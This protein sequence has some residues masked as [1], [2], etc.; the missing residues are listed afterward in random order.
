MPPPSTRS[1]SPMPVGSRV[2]VLIS[3]SASLAPALA[4]ERAV[5]MA[6]WCRRRTPTRSSTKEF[7]APQSVQRPSHLG[8]WRRIPGTRRR[9]WTSTPTIMVNRG[10]DRVPGPRLIGYSGLIGLIGL[11]ARTMDE[12]DEA[13]CRT[14]TLEAADHRADDGTQAIF[15]DERENDRG[16]PEDPAK[17]LAIRSRLEATMCRPIIPRTTPVAPEP[18]P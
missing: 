11:R 18:R 2:V 14:L 13:G 6:G 8:D 3:T 4:G 7:H 12:S 16:P 15:A 17:T 9:A 5:A 10:S 1:S